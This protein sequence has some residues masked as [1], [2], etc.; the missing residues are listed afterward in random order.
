MITRFQIG[1]S[2]SI[3]K[4]FEEHEVLEFSQMSQDGNPIHFDDEYASTT[5]F[6]KKIVQ[7]PFVASLIGGILGSHLPG[8]GT[9]YISQNTRF[10]KPV[11]VGEKVTASVQIT[12][13]RMD[14]PIM[15]LRTWV[16]N[17]NME[18]VIDGEATIYYIGN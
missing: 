18:V 3:S 15:N 2:Y 13:I 1:D 16:E 7:G 11:F 5:R 8:P 14:K 6:Q 9:I 10:L 4:L 12:R 17:E